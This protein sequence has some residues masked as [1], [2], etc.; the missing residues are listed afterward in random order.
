MSRLSLGTDHLIEHQL[1]IVEAISRD[2]EAI[3]SNLETMRTNLQAVISKF[4]AAGKLMASD[5]RVPYTAA[6]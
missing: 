3:M 5:P 2:L 1:A 4:E 6:P